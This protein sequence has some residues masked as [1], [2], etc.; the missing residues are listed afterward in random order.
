[1]ITLKNGEHAQIFLENTA[2]NK[3]ILVQLGTSHVPSAELAETASISINRQ[4]LKL[5]SDTIQQKRQQR[6]KE[7]AAS[8]HRHCFKHIRLELRDV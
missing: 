7:I 8:R 6:Q 5:G 2:G 4:L 1:M 3:L